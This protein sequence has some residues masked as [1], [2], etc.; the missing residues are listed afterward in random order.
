MQKDL[1][2]TIGD[3]KTFY[4]MRLYRALN[5]TNYSPTAEQADKAIKE[6]VNSSRGLD[7][8]NRLN[9]AEARAVLNG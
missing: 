2:K 3:N 1:I 8:A 6:L 5:D 9:E 4:G 7:E